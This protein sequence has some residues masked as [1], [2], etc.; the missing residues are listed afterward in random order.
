MGFTNYLTAYRLHLLKHVR[1]AFELN[2]TSAMG[3]AEIKAFV[4]QLTGESAIPI[5][6]ESFEWLSNYFRYV[7][8]KDQMF[9]YD[10]VD[11]LWHFETT[12]ASL[13][14]LLTDY[15]TVVADEAKKAKD[16]IFFRYANHFFGV[17]KIPNLAKR[18]KQSRLL[19]I[20][21][22]NEIIKGT[23]H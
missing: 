14:S 17:G 20:R 5:P 15:F 1:G 8:D 18:I 13:Q 2:D 21:K 3:E 10:N 4:K 23:E 11:G 12:D 9:V 19:H 6:S 22:S 7:E 16:Q